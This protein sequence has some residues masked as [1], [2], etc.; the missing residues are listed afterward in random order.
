MRI[1]V[2][3]EEFP[4]P[5]NTGKRIRS[6]NLNQ[7]LAA[8]H[9][10]HYVAFGSENSESYRTLHQAG[11]NPVTVAGGPTQKSGIGFYL[12]LLINMFD[13]RPYIVSSHY[14]HKYQSCLDGLVEKTRPDI[15]ICEWTPYAAYVQNRYSCRKIIVA[16]NIESIIWE[17]YYEN[18]SNMLRKWYI[19]KQY[20]KVQRFEQEALNW[21]DGFTAVSSVEV[22]QLSSQA[23]SA[24][25]EVIDNGVDLNYFIPS[26][27]SASGKELVFTGSMDWRPNQDA[28]LYFVE[29]IYPLL[30]QRD[31]EI[32]AT[33]VGRNPPERIERL[34]EIDG[35]AIT[36]T[37][38]DV[39]PYIDRAALYIVPLRIGGGSRLKILEALAMKKAVLST[40]VGAEGLDVCHGEDI[41]IADSAEPFAEKILMLLSDREFAIRLGENGRRLVEKSYGWDSLAEKLD[42]FLTTVVS[43]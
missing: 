23:P 33:F 18:E 13:R 37:V 8:R 9:E 34:N 24:L 42:Q 5:L 31:P 29:E 41:I 14:S 25:S 40:T 36:G 22:S 11:M 12:R 35:I 10:L 26:N 17:R 20:V 1:L 16:H 7:R 30:R 43:A 19:G 39:R 27:Q 28:A 15:I 32:T 38:D 21:V 4:W 2:L 3:D 6:Y